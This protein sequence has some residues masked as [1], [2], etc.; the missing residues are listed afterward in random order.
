MH[1][2]VQ[3]VAAVTVKYAWRLWGWIDRVSCRVSSLLEEACR[4]CG[5]GECGD[6]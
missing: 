1:T 2:E 3:V 6:S 4:V 5:E